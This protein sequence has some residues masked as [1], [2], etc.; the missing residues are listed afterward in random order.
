MNLPLHWQ[1]QVTEGISV[2][3]ANV[4]LSL[5]GRSVFVFSAAGRAARGLSAQ[6]PRVAGDPTLPI[7]PICPTT[8]ERSDLLCLSTQTSISC[9][10]CCFRLSNVSDKMWLHSPVGTTAAPVGLPGGGHQALSGAHG[11]SAGTVVALG[12]VRSPGQRSLRP[13]LTDGHHCVRV[14]ARWRG[15]AVPY[16]VQ[17]CQASGAAW[18]ALVAPGH[19]VSSPPS[20]HPLPSPRSDFPATRGVSSGGHTAACGSCP[21]RR[22]HP[23]SKET[24][25]NW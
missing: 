7:L 19:S 12:G 8:L 17:N 13:G 23:C 3:E 4:P 16:V 21:A 25:N 20:L 22:S 18:R 6:R 2:H 10:Y 9:H 14:V 15:C 11:R 24:R 5:P 1:G